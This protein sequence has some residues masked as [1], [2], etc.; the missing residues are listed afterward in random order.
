MST[1]IFCPSGNRIIVFSMAYESR[2]L[3]QYTSI[4]LP[5]LYSGFY[6]HPFKKYDFYA[7][8]HRS[9]QFHLLHVS[10][11][12]QQ[13]QLLDARSS[14]HQ[15]RKY[16]MNVTEHNVLSYGLDGMAILRSVATNDC[17]A[18][19]KP[20]HHMDLGIKT[21]VAN[22]LNTHIISLGQDGSMICTYLRTKIDQLKQAPM[23]CTLLTKGISHMY[24][25]SQ[26]SEFI[27]RT[28]KGIHIYWHSGGHVGIHFFSEVTI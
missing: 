18:F 4:D 19:I 28:D 12:K 3:I 8:P 25:E 1:R 11:E 16:A 10:L 15:L 23:R 27:N 9:R 6:V 13:L 7:I 14:G 17:K 2:E 5:G 24:T 21:A 20:H 26:T 22:P